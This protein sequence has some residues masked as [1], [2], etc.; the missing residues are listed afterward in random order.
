[1]TFKQFIGNGDTGIIGIINTVIVPVIFALAFL[2]FVWGIVNYFFISGGD[3]TKRA[4]G[5]QFTMWGII[6]IVVLFSVW[7]FVNL[8]LSTLGIMPS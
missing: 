5:R 2:V 8:L 1:M 7:G 3:E 6:V 4:E